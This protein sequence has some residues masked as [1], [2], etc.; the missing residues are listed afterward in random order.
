[1]CWE[2]EYKGMEI[3]EIARFSTL[4]IDTDT[5]EILAKI[6]NTE[7]NNFHIHNLRTDSTFLCLR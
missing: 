1:M 6:S 2:G 3:A 5:V 7:N 4:T